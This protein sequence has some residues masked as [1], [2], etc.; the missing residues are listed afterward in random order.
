MIDTGRAERIDLV[1][2][3]VSKYLR[4]TRHSCLHFRFRGLKLADVVAACVL[5]KSYDIQGGLHNSAIWSAHGTRGCY[6]ASTHENN[7][8]CPRKGP[9]GSMPGSK[10]EDLTRG[11]YCGCPRKGPHRSMPS[12]KHKSFEL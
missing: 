1:N 4:Y 11:K 3:K 5:H 8:I 9:H 10:F 7:C 12:S 6:R 2:D